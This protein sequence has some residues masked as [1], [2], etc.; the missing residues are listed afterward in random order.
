[1]NKQANLTAARKNK[2]DEFYTQLSDIEKELRQYDLKGKI[3]YLNTDNPKYSMF[4]KYFTL[5]FNHLGLKKIISTY[6]SDNKEVYRT[7]MINEKITLKK[8]FT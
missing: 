7:E 4:W 3:I 6:Y 5:N 2:N 1:M 8:I